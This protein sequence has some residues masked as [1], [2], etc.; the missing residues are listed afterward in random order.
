MTINLAT[1][2]GYEHLGATLDAL[3]GLWRVSEVQMAQAVRVSRPTLQNRFKGV[4]PAPRAD[5]MQRYVDFFG[6]PREVLCLPRDRAVVIAI[7]EYD[8]LGRAPQFKKR[9]NSTPRHRKGRG[10]THPGFSVPGG[11]QFRHIVI[12]RIEAA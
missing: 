6:L 4:G 5:E 9:G 2:E 12:T 10:G 3:R 8:F 1:S 11:D 7:Q